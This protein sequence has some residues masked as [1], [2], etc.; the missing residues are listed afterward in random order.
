M[1]HNIFGVVLFLLTIGM[2][3]LFGQSNGISWVT[4]FEEAK[5]ESLT[6]NKPIMMKFF[7]TRCGYCRAMDNNTFTNAEIIEAAQELISLKINA[8]T[9]EG[10]SLASRY[11]VNGFPTIVFVDGSGNVLHRSVGYYPPESFLNEIQQVTDHSSLME[12]HQPRTPDTM[13]PNN[14]IDEAKHM[15]VGQVLEDMNF[16]RSDDEDY[17]TFETEPNT[18]YTIKTMGE[19][20]TQLAILDK[21]GDPLY[22]DDD[23][24]TGHNAL[25]S[26]FSKGTDSITFMVFPYASD[27]ISQTYSLILTKENVTADPTEPNDTFS[28]ATSIQEGAPIEGT[29]H[30]PEDMDYYELQLQTGITYLLRTEGTTDT[31]LEIYNS[32]HMLIDWDDDSGEDRNALLV[33]PMVRESSLYVLVKPYNYEG[34]SFDYILH[35]EPLSSEEGDS[36]EP[37]NYP[38][39]ATPIPTQG[40]GLVSTLFP[41]YDI[42]LYAFDASANQSYLIETVCEVDTYLELY[43]TDQELLDYNDD[44][45]DGDI[46][47]RLIYSPETDMKLLIY[48]RGYNRD[49]TGSYTVRVE[50]TDEEPNTHTFLEDQPMEEM[51]GYPIEAPIAPGKVSGEYNPHTY[52]LPEAYRVYSNGRSVINYRVPG[53]QPVILP[54]VNDYTAT[55]GCYV[56]C[57]SHNTEGAVYS[58]GSNI[59]VKGQV[60]VRGEYNGR[61]CIPTDTEGVDISADQYFKDLCNESIPS[62]INCWAGGDTGGWFGL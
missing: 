52:L 42:D 37:N 53:F 60:R 21:S 57:Y 59:F 14:A 41:Q 3:P 50:E 62:C 38:G 28:T 19:S 43:S 7:T 6:S 45:A 55:P 27:S 8:E 35:V 36:F 9:S 58:V 25:L 40:D 39:E 12:A 24:G 11:S 32:D 44:K 48:I 16:H 2:V 13:E 46:C 5:Q 61:I 47:S 51:E 54:T 1:Y 56:A 34:E 4:S 49:M 30:H 23:S 15:E 22:V 29:F 18:L 31:I 33:H 20:D 17:F 10:R 26:F